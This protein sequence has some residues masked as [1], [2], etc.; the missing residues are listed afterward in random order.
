M[1]SRAKIKAALCLW[2]LA[3]AQIAQAEFEYYRDAAGV[4]VVVGAPFVELYVQPG[5]G[6]PRFHAV[7][8]NERLRIVK[9]RNDWYKVETTDGKSG[10]ARKRDLHSL[11]DLDGNPLEF[12]PSRASDEEYP[13]RI[14]LLAG[15]LGSIP[16]YTFYAG[17]RFTPN[18]ST[19]LKYAQA[20]GASS[21]IKIASLV[22]VHQAFP[23]WRVT[24]FLYLG[25]GSVETLRE[26][27]LSQAADTRDTALTV[28]GG[29]MTHINHRVLARVEY[30]KHTVLTTQESNQEV[31]EWKA[32]F[33]VLF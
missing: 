5:R 16:A 11:T 13:W 18:L 4:D 28:G 6:F 24:P 26:A 30:S 27:R 9:S 12:A 15:Q 10:W 23:D 14:G 8:K 1:L 19:E 17:Y 29:L 25:A 33:S 2:L 3:C 21:T 7:E 20:F 32:G 31:A 22:L